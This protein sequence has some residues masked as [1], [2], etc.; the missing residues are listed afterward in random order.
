MKNLIYLLLCL[1]SAIASADIHDYIK[2][3]PNWIDPIEWQFKENPKASG[4]Q[5][6]L[7]DS[8]YK[9]QDNE[10]VH[11][12][13]HQVQKPLTIDAVNDSGKINIYFDP[14]YE[15]VEVH[16]LT[17]YREGKKLDRTLSANYRTLDSEPEANSNLY[18]GE[19]QLFVL[20]QDIRV[21]DIVEFKYSII[22]NNPVFPNKISR[23][24]SLGWGVELDKLHFS[25]QYPADRHIRYKAFEIE[26]EPEIVQTNNFSKLSVNLEDL[27]AYQAEENMPSN[28]YA[29]PFLQVT[30]YTDWPDVTLWAKALFTEDIDL[31]IN[32]P[33]WKKW[34]NK[35]EILS[36][37][38]DK[39]IQALFLVQNN[40]RYVGIE[41]GINS[42]KP[43]A[44]GETLANRY[45]DC[46]DKTLLLVELLKALNIQAEPVLVNTREK[47]GILNLLPTP[48]AFNHVITRVKLGDQFY[49]LDPT[50]DHQGGTQLKQIGYYN[51]GAGLPVFTETNLIEMPS[52][53]GTANLRFFNETFTS[54]SY[55][56]PVKLEVKTI[57]TGLEAEHQRSRF[58]NNSLESISK[59]YLDYY[60][61][62]YERVEFLD[63][64]SYEDNIELNRF[65]I[66]EAYLI[67]GFWEK[68]EQDNV[69]EYS[70]SATEISGLL[71]VKGSLNRQY[72]YKLPDNLKV[73]QNISVVLPVEYYSYDQPSESSVFEN[74]HFKVTVSNQDYGN[75]VEYQFTYQSLDPVVKNTS[76]RKHA[77]LAKKAK[78]YMGYSGWIDA[79]INEEYAP[80]ALQFY[81][82]LM[83]QGAQTCN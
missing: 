34:I 38:E 23:S 30:E 12:F 26:L 44:P 14:T 47:S 16:E 31:S 66:T 22:G 51:M 11:Y 50:L 39:I 20:I 59:N 9:S 41:M 77:N 40:I 70:V 80:P 1:T 3:T 64:I 81:C 8:Q 75:L 24:T 73:Q 43:H 4:T 63:Q 21:N 42:H 53:Q 79:A 71:P 25:I 37:N 56:A 35:L 15:T 29:Y 60:S 5:Y 32:N 83:T 28:E 6:I 49:Y 67:E 46:K 36:T 18:N 54:Y 65:S 52:T 33:E 45:G 69:Y 27:P 76:I 55:Q 82:D 19:K 74:D 7:V 61:N 17:I 57:Y 62:L 78:E 10:P 13:Y 2:P 58:L 72:S 68:N 48:N